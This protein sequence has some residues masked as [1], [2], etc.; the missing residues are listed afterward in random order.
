MKM[1]TSLKAQ[2]LAVIVGFALLSPAAAR[3]NSPMGTTTKAGL[4]GQGYKCELVGVGFWECTKA[5]ETTYWC[6]S[7]SCQPK[8][9]TLPKGHKLPK[10]NLDNMVVTQ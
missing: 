1:T 10:P 5:G 7:G 2:L 8:P 3:D 4:E 6:D 9:R